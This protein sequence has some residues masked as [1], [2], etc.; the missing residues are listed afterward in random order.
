[1]NCLLLERLEQFENDIRKI[2][3]VSEEMKIILDGF[4][5]TAHPMGV[6]SALTSALTAFNP[7]SVDA[8]NEKEMYDASL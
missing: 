3:L 5:R 7:K 2:T 4:P 1:M 8:D 6:L